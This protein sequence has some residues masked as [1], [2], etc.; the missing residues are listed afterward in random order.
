L[1]A[2]VETGLNGDGDVD[3]GDAVEIGEFAAHLV[4]GSHGAVPD[5]ATSNE[6]QRADC[7]PVVGPFGQ[8]G[9]GD[10]DLGDFIQALRFA[11]LLDPVQLASGPA[12]PIPAFAGLRSDKSGEILSKA[13]NIRVVDTTASAGSQVTV[14]IEMDAQ[15][16]D[17]GVSF[18][19]DYDAAKLSNPSVELGTGAAGAFLIT[20]ADTPG[21]VAVQL[22]HVFGEFAAGASQTLSITF[23]VAKRAKGGPTQ[24]T[25]TD[26]LAERQIRDANNSETKSVFTGGTVTIFGPTAANVAFWRR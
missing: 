7:E 3:L 16:G 15:P 8:S 23:D 24:L 4:T 25:F 22:A 21:N 10:V 18:T 26:D 2:D 6:F 5:F 11:N 9:D 13:R 20:N 1:E 12:F 19:M 17:K 14:S